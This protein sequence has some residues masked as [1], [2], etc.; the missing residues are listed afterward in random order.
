VAAQSNTW[1]CVRSLAGI[2]VFES[3][4]VHGCASLVGVVSC[5]V[6]ASAS[7]L[8]HVQRSPIDCGA[9]SVTVKP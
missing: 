9:F 4:R 3:R 8:S 1:V 7:G 5:Q 2:A 6:E